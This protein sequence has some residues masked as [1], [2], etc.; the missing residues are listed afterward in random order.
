L[1]EKKKRL[2]GSDSEVDEGDAKEG[3]QTQMGAYDTLTLLG[4]ATCTIPSQTKG[5]TETEHLSSELNKIELNKTTNSPL[6]SE[7][8]KQTDSIEQQIGALNRSSTPTDDNDEID[9]DLLS[10]EE[11]SLAHFEHMQE[12][13]L[14]A[15]F[16]VGTDEGE[17][18]SADNQ[19]ESPVDSAPATNRCVAS[20]PRSQRT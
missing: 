4:T 20:H 10:D 11:D 12:N 19:E 17:Q 5:T 18:T 1:K 15:H 14:D 16:N 6:I 3:K 8:T 2:D 13:S 7:N 9:I